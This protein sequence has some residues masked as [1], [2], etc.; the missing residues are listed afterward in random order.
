[1]K[2]FGRLHIIAMGGYSVSKVIKTL[3]RYLPNSCQ[4]PHMHPMIFYSSFYNA[5]IE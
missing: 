1:M 3:K 2:A 5:E 4:D